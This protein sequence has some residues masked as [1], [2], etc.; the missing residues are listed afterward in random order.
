[1]DNAAEVFGSAD[2]R[3]VPYCRITVSSPWVVDLHDPEAENTHT[4]F[5]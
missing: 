5:Q 1:L 3:L 2:K 4:C